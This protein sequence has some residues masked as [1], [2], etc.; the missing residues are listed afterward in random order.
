MLLLCGKQHAFEDFL[1]WRGL[2]V[3]L[4]LEEA[5]LAR[6]V[7]EKPLAYAVDGQRCNTAD[8]LLLTAGKHPVSNVLDDEFASFSYGCSRRCTCR[9]DHGTFNERGYDRADTST[10]DAA[11]FFSK[12]TA[13]PSSFILPPAAFI[14]CVGAGHEMPYQP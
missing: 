4:S 13:F 10:C 2:V 9:P 11:T 8:L 12:L 7:P 1:T 5:V 3:F 6:A 14:A